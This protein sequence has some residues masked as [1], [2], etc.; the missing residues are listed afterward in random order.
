MLGI[1]LVSGWAFSLGHKFSLATNKLFRA[2]VF[3]NIVSSMLFLRDKFLPKLAC[4]TEIEIISL[5]LDEKTAFLL[6]PDCHSP[7]FSSITTVPYTLCNPHLF[8]RGSVQALVASCTLGRYPSCAW[9][10]V[11]WIQ[12]C[13]A[14]RHSPG[15]AL[16]G[17]IRVQ[18][19]SNHEQTLTNGLLQIP[20]SLQQ[21]KVQLRL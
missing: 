7:S 15:L 4:S 17:P 1:M 14:D 21:V 20:P 12:Q 11:S 8:V 3:M 5:K 10:V 16:S 18:R 13:S 2:V 19:A 9:K 6:P